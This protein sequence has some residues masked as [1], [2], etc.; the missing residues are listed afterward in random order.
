MSQ[1]PNSCSMQNEEQTPSSSL[2]WIGKRIIDFGI[3]VAFVKMWGQTR[4]LVRCN[5][6][7]SYQ[8]ALPDETKRPRRREK[9]NSVNKWPEFQTINYFNISRCACK[10]HATTHIHTRRWSIHYSYAARTMPYT[11]CAIRLAPG[12]RPSCGIVLLMYRMPQQHHHHRFRWHC[13]WAQPPWRAAIAMTS[14]SNA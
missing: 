12:A 8:L 13:D 11:M 4:S 1:L 2:P 9:K 3:S 6:S 14:T 7:A 10:W 5:E